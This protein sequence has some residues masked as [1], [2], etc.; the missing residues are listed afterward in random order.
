MKG[1]ISLLDVTKSNHGKLCQQFV[2][3]PMMKVRQDIQT[4]IVFGLLEYDASG[5]SGFLSN[6]IMTSEASRS[7]PTRNL[8]AYIQTYAPSLEWISNKKGKRFVKR[9]KDHELYNAPTVIPLE[10][11]EVWWNHETNNNTKAPAALDIH[12]KILTL[13]K[14][15]MGMTEA[16]LISQIKQARSELTEKQAKK[17]NVGHGV[18]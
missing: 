2:A 6:V 18:R 9:D 15:T 17:L 10:A 5:N 14:Q 8:I 13:V 1:N 16:E 7:I 11:G 4:L 12:A 3:R